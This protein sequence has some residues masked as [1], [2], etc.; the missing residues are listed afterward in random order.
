MYTQDLAFRTA[1]FRYQVNRCRA[2][3]HPKLQNAGDKQMR[4]C[5]IFTIVVTLIFT[6]GVSS[7]QD[8]VEVAFPREKQL[9]VATKVFKPLVY[10]VNDELVGFSIDL[11]EVLADELELEYDL[12]VTESV[13][14]L[15]ESVEKGDADIGI[16]GISITEA[17]EGVVDFSHPYFDA[18]LQI[19]VPKTRDHS[20]L[21]ALKTLY[22]PLIVQVLGLLFLIVLVMAHCIWF[23][24]RRKNTEQFP[25][26]YLKGIW[27]SFWWASV[28]LTTVGYGDKSPRGVV[29]RLLGLFWMFVGIVLISYFTAMVTTQLTVDRLEGEI[30]KPSDLAGRKVATVRGST[31]EKFLEKVLARVH[32]LDDFENALTVLETGQVEALV[33]DAPVLI[34]Y[35]NH[36]GSNRFRVVGSIFDH[37][38]YGIALQHGSPLRE[39]LNRALLR[40]REDGRYEHIYQ[41]WFGR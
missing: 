20:V 10:R 5:T 7:A 29:G 16:A 22:V 13:A 36:E 14:G 9:V 33:Y 18:G 15:I 27:E 30:S 28:T 25:S 3:R 6:C 34:Y 40:L 11:L 39:P 19:L 12:R 31:S 8:D 17:R 35:A 21:G 26:S 37:Q 23:A 32:A 1:I 24:E 2:S 38:S 41:K 4:N